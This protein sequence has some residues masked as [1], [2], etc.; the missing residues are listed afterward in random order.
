MNKIFPL[1]LILF[2]VHCVPAQNKTNFGFEFD[3]AQF[4]YDTTSNY[5]EIYYS[6]NQ[7]DLSINSTDSSQFLKGILKISIEDTSSKKMLVDKEW[8]IVN[9]VK[10]SIEANKSLVGVLGFV[11]PKGNYK[12]IVEGR[13]GKNEEKKRTITDHFSIV[14]MW[15]HNVSISDVQFASRIIQDSPN[16]NSIFYKNTFEIIPM[17]INVFGENQPVVFYY[18]ELY[19][20]KDISDNKLKLRSI[21]YNSRGK[22]ISEKVKNISHSINSRVE[23]GTVVVNKYPTDSYILTEA[24]VDSADNVGISSSKRFY[25]Y[26]PSIAHPDT[27]YNNGNAS[28]L[29][30]EFSVMNEDE[31]DKVF[32]ESKYIA[33]PAEI[34]QYKT[35]KTL[36][37]KKKF[38]YDFW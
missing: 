30:S 38:L 17:T 12:I 10:D 33:V 24:L 28:A 21:I 3:Y 11:I 6:F 4:G 20:L 32:A 26:N 37:G 34:D 18:V 8:N 19:N 27:L 7:N 9:N 23:V 35:I 2:F 31:L 22:V 29:G 16:K 14:P 13:D 36:E 15:R 5:V 25:V 1:F